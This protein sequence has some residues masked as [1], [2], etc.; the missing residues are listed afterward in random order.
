[1]NSLVGGALLVGRLAP[2]PSSHLPVKHL[3]LHIGEGEYLLIFIFI[4]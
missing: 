4:N 3:G 2:E 1:M